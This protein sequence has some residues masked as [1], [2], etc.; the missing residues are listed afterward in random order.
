MFN[1]KK[2]FGTWKLKQNGKTIYKGNLKECLMIIV[3]KSRTEV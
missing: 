3:E 2:S 1:L